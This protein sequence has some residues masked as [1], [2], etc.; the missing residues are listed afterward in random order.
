MSTLHATIRGVSADDIEFVIRVW[1]DGLRPEEIQAEHPNLRLSQ[2]Y[3]LIAVHLAGTE[4]S[5]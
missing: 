3:G 5:K 2:V 1:G 4:G